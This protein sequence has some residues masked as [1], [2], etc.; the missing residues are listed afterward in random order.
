[1][2]PSKRTAV[3]RLIVA[4]TW[5]ALLVSIATGLALV[6]L[7]ITGSMIRVSH[8]V[9]TVWSRLARGKKSVTSLVVTQHAAP[10]AVAA[11]A[12]QSEPSTF[13]TVGR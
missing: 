7:V 3:D 1:M 12:D 9:R 5:V 4:G 11:F 2:P 6:A 10:D 8:D 13:D